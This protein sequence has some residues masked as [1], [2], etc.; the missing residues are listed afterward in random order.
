[1]KLEKTL[2]YLEGQ[3]PVASPETD[4]YI[5]WVNDSDKSWRLWDQY[6]A[7]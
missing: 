2:A 1:M 6:L 5:S 4:A 7:D 3:L